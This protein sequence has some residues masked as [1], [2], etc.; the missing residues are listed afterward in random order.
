MW[1][2]GDIHGSWQWL[3]KIL[4]KAERKKESVIQL[5]DFGIGFPTKI[6]KEYDY[7]NEGSFLTYPPELPDSFRFIRGNHDHPDP[8]CHDWRLCNA[9]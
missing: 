5:G 9:G 6:P 4:A 7:N 3:M 1:L 8:G 2:L